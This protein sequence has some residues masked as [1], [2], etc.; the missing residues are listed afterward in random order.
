MHEK[1]VAMQEIADKLHISK[2]SVFK[3]LSNRTDISLEL[4]EKILRTATKLGYVIED[5]LFKLCKKVYFII[6]Q[7]FVFSTEQF[8]SKIYRKISQKFE[9]IKIETI[10]MPISDNITDY[11]LLQQIQIERKIGVIIAGSTQQAV[12]N[13]LVKK[14]IPYISIDNY[15]ENHGGNYIYIDDYHSGYI[16]T[17]YLIKK[18]HKKIDFFVSLE[19]SNNLDK[20]F[21]Y[22]KALIENNL[23][24]GV[25]KHHDVDL[26][27]MSNFSNF[28]FPSELPDAFLFQSDH[29]AANFML[30]AYNN[31]YKIP[32]DFSI[33]SFDNTDIC[34]ETTPRLTSI[35][36]N[37]EELCNVCYDNLLFRFTKRNTGPQL[38][39]LS[40]NII[41]GESIKERK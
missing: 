8:Y 11:Q 31:G 41:V 22:K 12:L 25:S 32:K 15:L 3:A 33:A 39:I 28:V 17:N 5:P 14:S 26:S 36:P 13:F 27:V 30:V 23:D 40:S 29:A 37:Y 21:G 20:Y 35:G 19:A 1:K 10:F 18:G 34:L 24:N 4:R 6:S 16:I 9:K 38:T 2:G 7:K